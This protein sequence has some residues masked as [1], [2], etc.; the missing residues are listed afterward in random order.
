MAMLYLPT[1][2]G[3][4]VYVLG[5][6]DVVAL[7]AYISPDVLRINALILGSKVLILDSY[8]HS[9][10]RYSDNSGHL[11]LQVTDALVFSA[12]HLE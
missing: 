2:L 8:N 3:Y 11:L 7:V 4:S 5:S 6:P 9:G 1:A 12:E 10:V